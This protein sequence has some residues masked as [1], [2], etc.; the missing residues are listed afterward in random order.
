MCVD[1]NAADI[2]C[3]RE[4]VALPGFGNVLRESLAARKQ[5]AYCVCVGVSGAWCA[6][7]IVPFSLVSTF[8]SDT[9]TTGKERER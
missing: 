2:L 6:L 5:N 8:A 3:N 1:V 4:A 9:G 7:T